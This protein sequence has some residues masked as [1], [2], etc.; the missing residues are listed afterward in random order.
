[1]FIFLASSTAS[2]AIVDEFLSSVKFFKL[3][4]FEPDI[5]TN[6]IDDTT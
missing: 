2:A 4:D 6:H 1:M 3:I 5:N